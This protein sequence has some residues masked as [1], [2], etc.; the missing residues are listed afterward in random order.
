MSGKRIRGVTLFCCAVLPVGQLW[1][2]SPP[3]RSALVSTRPASPMP[4]G[5]PQPTEFK[6]EILEVIGPIAELENTGPDELS[7]R[8]GKG[9]GVVF[10]FS[11]NL[12]LSLPT[13][14]TFATRVPGAKGQGA[15]ARVSYEKVTSAVAVS[16]AWKGDQADVKLKVEMSNPMVLGMVE[17][18]KAPP[19]PLALERT[20]QASEGK[21]ASFK[22]ED[23]PAS[24]GDKT[25]PL[26]RLHVGKLTV[27]HAATGAA[28]APSSDRPGPQLASLRFEVFALSAKRSEIDKAD[29]SELLAPSSAGG[30][31][32]RRLS[33]YG[34]AYQ[35]SDIR[36][37]LDLA[38]GGRLT[39]SARVP[40]VVDVVVSASGVAVP[41]ITYEHVGTIL[42]IK[43]T[44][45]ERAGDRWVSD[46]DMKVETA[47]INESAVVASQVVQLPMFANA[48]YQGRQRLQS[49][50]PEY[51][52]CRGSPVPAKADGIV[53]L[54]VVRC[55]LTRAE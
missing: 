39:T 22:F 46:V 28:T 32:L 18:E 3:A 41:S 44:R 52:V 24:L 25:P 20:V 47:G 29:L 2:Q 23:K 9:G 36:A 40:T 30:D 27:K 4:S 45:W 5:P 21:T 49:G 6:L 33:K 42:W 51:F 16:G 13:K 26:G 43:P 54:Y 1:G 53:P 12:D 34:E 35:A 38:E 17:N 31:I 8:V 48:A 14:L 19:Q 37:V 15:K 55:T 50:R 7:D 10:S 11:G